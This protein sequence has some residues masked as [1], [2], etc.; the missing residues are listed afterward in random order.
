[1][2][3]LQ[4]TAK[5]V[6]LS[7]SGEIA[8]KATKKLSTI[9]DSNFTTKI[10]SI[11]ALDVQD[12]RTFHGGAQ[13][14][15][16]GLY[17]LEAIENDIKGATK[18]S[19]SAGAAKVKKFEIYQDIVNRL[20]ALYTLNTKKYKLAASSTTNEISDIDKVSCG[21]N[22]SKGNYVDCRSSYCLAYT[23]K[24]IVALFEDLS[25]MSNPIKSV[26]DALK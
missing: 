13:A 5:D 19:C 12:L 16:C 11:V 7:T 4:Y 22:R 20:S 10:R 2:Q 9:I 21:N 26:T 24:K 15:L 3:F 8:N 1:V 23:V 25:P 18:S 6:G 14:C 17:L